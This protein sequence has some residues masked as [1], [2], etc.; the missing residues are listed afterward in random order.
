M[1][2]NIDNTLLTDKRFSIYM[3]VPYRTKKYFLPE[4][5]GKTVIK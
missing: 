4:R 1:F 2:K 3:H 5:N